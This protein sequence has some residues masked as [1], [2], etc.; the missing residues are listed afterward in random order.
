M[1]KTYRWQ[2]SVDSW[3]CESRQSL[4]RHLAQRQM[5][6][7]LACT[8]EVWEHG[9][10]ETTQGIA[11]VRCFTTT[12]KFCGWT[13][14][15]KQAQQHQITEYICSCSTSDFR[16]RVFILHVIVEVLH[17]GTRV[18]TCLNP[19]FLLCWP[20]FYK[21]HDGLDVDAEPLADQKLG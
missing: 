6:E 5:W 17:T 4:G 21:V 14:S 8:I 15:S 10:K 20:G 2:C 19:F 1:Q 9:R 18:S 7:S 11:D 16:K 3:I 13:Q 12:L